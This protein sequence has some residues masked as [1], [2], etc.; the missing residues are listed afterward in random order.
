MCGG[1]PISIATAGS[2][3]TNT[4]NGTS[5][6]NTTLANSIPRGTFCDSGSLCFSSECLNAC[7]IGTN[8]GVTSCNCNG[9][10]AKPDYYCGVN[11][12]NLPIPTC[13]LSACSGPDWKCA[14]EDSATTCFATAVLAD[15][16]LTNGT[17][18]NMCPSSQP[19]SSS[20]CLCNGSKCPAGSIC[21]TGICDYGDTT[22]SVASEDFNAA[23]KILSF[24]IVATPND[25]NHIVTGINATSDYPGVPLNLNGTY[26]KNSG[27]ANQFLFAGIQIVSCGDSVSVL[28]TAEVCLVGGQQQTATN[29]GSCRPNTPSLQKSFTITV[30]TT[31]DCLITLSLNTF[32]VDGFVQDVNTGSSTLL[33]SMDTWQFVLH[34]D[35]LLKAGSYINVKSA[36]INDDTATIALDSSC[37][38]LLNAG[39]GVT[40]FTVVA[41]MMNSSISTFK[42]TGAY[43]SVTTQRCAGIDG[44]FLLAGKTA[45]VTYHFSFDL[46][47]TSTSP[48]KTV[49]GSISVSSSAVQSAKSRRDSPSVD[50]TIPKTGRVDLAANVGSTILGNGV[51]KPKA[52]PVSGTTSLSAGV[53]IAILA[54]VV[55]GVLMTVAIIFGFNKYRHSK[56]A[57]LDAKGKKPAAHEPTEVSSFIVAA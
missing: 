3:S 8:K 33:A 29:S 45:P 57:T 19:F 42:D 34:S 17:C 13:G 5:T 41:R 18:Y 50:S 35:E 2:L 10:E 36:T 51:S 11:T 26:L 6:S 7:D 52:S 30:S 37:F 23:S 24:I 1:K 22:F 46:D 38:V 32:S 39:Y 56:A 16:T 55:M 14:C 31:S 49:G 54:G 28:F 48:P 43:K 44:G 20:S 9:H 27:A 21:K 25:T 4:A 47:F 15:G 53:I 40:T 12:T